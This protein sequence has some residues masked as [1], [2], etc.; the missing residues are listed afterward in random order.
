[1]DEAEI[2]QLI[3]HNYPIKAVGLK[4]MRDGGSL[5]Y[6]LFAEDKC[7]FL[8]IVKP[9][10]YETALNAANVHTYLE[11]KGFAV[12]PLVHARNGLPYILEKGP[13]G[14]QITLL[15]EFIVG[16]EVD[17][18]Q[19]AEKIG[20]T[21][22]RFHS[23]MKG[24]AG[25]LVKR[26]KYYF[27]DRYTQLLRKKRYPRADEFQLYGD[28]LWDKV[29]NLPQGYCHG[30]MYRGNI[31]KTLDGKLF[32]LDLDTSCHAFP[33]FDAVLICNMTDY[34]KFNPAGYGQTR[35]VFKRF[36]TTYTKHCSVSRAEAEAF[37]DLI[38]VY[39]F[40]LQATIIEMYGLTCVDETFLDNQLDW[41]YKWREQCALNG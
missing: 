24:Y 4:F 23:A 37:F 12:P 22:G 6:T 26:D 2:L 14:S 27:I 9:A 20:E 38:A 32:I 28:S 29:K 40:Q 18:E 10:F 5:S 35:D 13:D 11:N 31:H 1:M 19:D 3:N 39:H 7:Y 34:F 25:P 21:L 8:K 16:D 17:P 15:Y 30:D 41:L 33:I 36:L